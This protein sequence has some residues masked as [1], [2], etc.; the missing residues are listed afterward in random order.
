MTTLRRTVFVAGLLALAGCLD[1]ALPETMNV[2][3]D[4]DADADSDV[5]TDGGSDADTDSDMDTDGGSDADSDPCDG[6]TCS[7]HGRCLTDRGTAVCVC[8]EGYHAVGLECLCT[9]NCGGRECGPDSC[10]GECPPGCGAGGMCDEGTGLCATV[11]WCDGTSGLCW[12]DPPRGDPIP[13]YSAVDYCHTLDLGGHGPGSW[14]MPTISELRSLIRGCPENMTGGRCGVT[15]SCLDMICYDGCT[16]CP[17]LGGPGTDGAYWPAGVS[18]PVSWYWS[19]SSLADSSSVAF[20][21]YF[22]HGYVGYA[23]KTNPCYVRCVRGGP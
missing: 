10:G 8:D 18:G 16:A 4:G 6:V 14:R 17:V 11:E 23:A 2:E 3:A 22:N 5:D 9:P 12:Q 7:G 1:W 21:V 13:W 20:Y 15:D 19:S